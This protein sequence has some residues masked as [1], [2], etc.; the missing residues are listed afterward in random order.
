MIVD[1]LNVV[2]V[3]ILPGKTDP[4]SIVYANTVAS[5][6]VALQRF[7]PVARRPKV[8]KFPRL[9]QEQQFSSGNA[10][11]RLKPLDRLIVEQLRGVGAGKGADQSPFYY[12][13]RNRSTQD[14]VFH[15]LWV[16]PS[17]WRAARLRR[18]PAPPP[19]SRRR[20]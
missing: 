14:Y 8:G 1:D 19:A 15:A 20:C 4:P 6:P 10:L 2:C 7:Q 9:M 12:V 16:T 3:A 18:A 5:S 17:G 11:D 13:S